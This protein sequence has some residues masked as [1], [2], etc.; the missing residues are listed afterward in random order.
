MPRN[1]SSLYAA[2]C[3]RL[4][5]SGSLKAQ[6]V[7]HWW[8]PREAALFALGLMTDQIIQAISEG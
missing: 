6:G 3:C 7:A 8:R 5:E 2:P 4:Q 1:G